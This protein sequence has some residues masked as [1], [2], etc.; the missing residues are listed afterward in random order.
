[1]ISP[2]ARYERYYSCIPDQL[3]S[4]VSVSS[5][6][7]PVAEGAVAILSNCIMQFSHLQAPAFEVVIH[8]WSNGPTVPREVHKESKEIDG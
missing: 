3:G 6:S 4:F 1:M 2:P 8:T 7:E 5:R